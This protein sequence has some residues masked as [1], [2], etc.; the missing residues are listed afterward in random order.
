MLS[1]LRNN[2]S[3]D[4]EKIKAGYLMQSKSLILEHLWEF[5]FGFTHDTQKIEGSTLTKKETD[6]L[7]RFSLTP[8]SKPE[9][10]MIET[11]M[12]HQTYHKMIEKLPS[13]T[14]KVIMLWHKE[15]FKSTKPEFA[16]Q[17]RKYPVYVTNSESTFPHW[18]FVPKFVSEFLK[19][20]KKSQKKMEPVELAGI[21]HFRFVSIHPFGDGN[22]RISRLLMNYILI[23]N[24]CP[25]L[26]IRFA[27]R[28]KY[29]QALE[30]GQTM[31]D[32]IYFLKWFIKYYVRANKKYM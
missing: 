9:S 17:L 20:Y 12:H 24:N 32:E 15:M 29:Y 5:S 25:P 6:D 11:K 26:N 21:A 22:G 18:K 8:H 27:D 30:K 3:A 31:L 28:K 2:W 4:L 23:K 13:L 10:D 19:W 7:L 16:A 1:V 14:Y